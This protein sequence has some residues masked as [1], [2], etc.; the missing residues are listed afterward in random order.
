[1][2]TWCGRWT[3]L[4]GCAMAEYCLIALAHSG[5]EPAA[6][7][8]PSLHRVKRKWVWNQFF[9]LEEHLETEPLY[10]GKLHSDSD[11]GNGSLRY[12]L[13]GDGAGTIFTIDEDNGD[14]FLLKKLDREEKPFYILRAQVVDRATNQ[15][16]EPESEF[17]IKVQ[18]INDNEPQFLDEPYVATVPERSPDGTFVTQVTA[19]DADDPSYGSHARVVYYILQGQP[20]FL[21]EPTTGVIRVASPNTDREAEE[22]HVVIIEAKDMA[23]L[24]GGLSVTTTVTITLSDVNDNRPKFQHKLY[25]FS[26]L[27]S[28]SIGSTVGRIMATDVDIGQNA[29]MDYIVEAGDGSDSFA[30]IT[31]DKTQ[32][33]VIKLKKPLDYESKGRFS[34]RVVA[35]NRH[36]DPRLLNLGP[37]KDVTNVKINVLDVDEP[38]V[39]VSPEYIFKIQENRE[40]GG[41]VGEVT[42]RDPDAANN[43]IRYSIDHHSD[44]TFNIDPKNGTITTSQPL[45]REEV[46]W[47]NLT[48]SASEASNVK[49]V[50]S[51]LVHIQVLDVNDHPPEFPVPYKTFVCENAKHGQLIQTISAVD[52]DEPSERQHFYFTLAPGAASNPNFTVRDHQDNTAAILTQRAGYRRGELAIHFLPILIVDNGTPSLSSTNTLTIR[53]CRCSNNGAGQLCNA[54]AFFLPAGLSTGAF[55]AIL[56]CAVMILALVFLLLVLRRHRK[57]PHFAGECDDIRENIVRYDDEG[58]GEEDTE[59]FS[60]ATLRNS[61]VRC[62]CRARRDVKS[63]IPSAYRQS[64]RGMPD[65][66]VF[67]EFVR[68][69][70]NE[71]DSDPSALPFDSLQT[72]AFEGTGS[73]AESLSSLAS[74]CMGSD[75]NYDYLSDW[76]LC[77]GT[78]ADLYGDNGNHLAT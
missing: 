20:Y 18:D 24:K 14:I 1:M 53:V 77:F 57:D 66:A 40:A 48:I 22:Q 60:M 37:F 31:D 16:V 67:R 28:G 29:E 45:D 51:V 49:K 76:G 55:I 27:E 52:K 46:P 10:I 58:G 63:D 59:A 34:I 25:H 2:L 75:E 65:Q 56:I 5:A 44:R 72:Y 6:N 30:V 47:Y 61:R 43:S 9:V 4:M 68:E 3:I 23:G 35:I 74:S 32:E 7:R 38:P 13:T 78:L 64:L 12:N 36:I 15:H 19:T 50:T 21:V 39:F 11:N 17:L 62:G 69:R 26:V 33:G 71:A 70:L 54:D 42:A 73:V 41:F 8:L